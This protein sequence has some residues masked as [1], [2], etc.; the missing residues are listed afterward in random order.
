MKH[1]EQ[2]KRDLVVALDFAEQI[3][4]NPELLDEIPEGSVITFLDDETVI[5][6]NK[7]AETP[8]RKYVKV[9]R[10]FELL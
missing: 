5:K 8:G 4:E 1:Y 9:K 6:E 7:Q 10:S 3:I 2:V